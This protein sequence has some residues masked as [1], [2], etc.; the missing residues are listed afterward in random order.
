MIIE[1][2]P[3]G[4]LE[5]N[6]YLIAGDS[7]GPG[8]VIDPGDES[9]RLL[10]AAEHLGIDIEKIVVTHGHWD[11]IGALAE[12]ADATGAEV[13]IHEDDAE[14]LTDPRKNLSG[15]VSEGSE[16]RADRTVT[17][18]E[19]INVGAL[20]LHVLHTPGHTP[21]GMSLLVDG[22]LFCGDLIFYD[23]MGRTDLPGGNVDEMHRSVHGKAMVL[24]DDTNIFPG[25]GPATTVVREREHNPYL[26]GGW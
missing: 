7:G 5:T 11:H 6:C 9:V 18:G 17:D 10:A 3:V 12:L 16:G 15:L 14:Y 21:G 13:L 1:T 2:I 8:A 23:S 25:H 26:T 20:D 4:A 24:P 19:I 22:N